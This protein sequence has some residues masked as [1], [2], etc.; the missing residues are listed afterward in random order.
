MTSNPDFK[1]T[2]KLLI[3]IVFSVL[4]FWLFSQS[5]LN[6]APTVQ[7]SLNLSSSVLNIGI[8]ITSLFSGL[9]IVL[10]GKLSDKLGRMKYVY[11]GL[12][13]NIIGSLILIS[14]NNSTLFIFGRILQG[15]SAAAIMPAT[16]SLIKVYYEGKDRQRALSYW[17]IGSW[18]GSG[19][20]SFFGG[21]LTSAFGWRSV[22][23][24]SIVI[25]IVSIFLL[26]GTPESFSIDEDD[27]KFDLIGLVLFI[28]SVLALNIF[29]T[30][31]SSLGWTSTI[32]IILVAV[33]VI[34]IIVFYKREKIAKNPFIDFELF[35]N[36]NYTAATLSNFL[37]NAVAGTMIVINSY[38]QQGR[39]LS[40]IQTGFLS[41]GYLAFVLITIRI[42]E[43]VLQK[44]GP[45]P[46][47]IYGSILA[48][49]GILLMDIT[50]LNGIAYLIAVFVGYSLFGIGLGLYATPSTDTAVSNVPNEKVGVAS[51]IYKMASS[52]G[53]AIGVAISA[54][55][56]NAIDINGQY[57]LGA[58]FGLGVNILFALLSLVSIV[59]LIKPN[60]KNL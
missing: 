52:L 48:V 32:S 6:I 36:G 15:L 41:L 4:T 11:I 53:G 43:K 20:C 10:A 19:F 30:K 16:I 24:F 29:I 38:V 25:S 44:V 3:G 26:K 60:N 13:L 59:L 12:F 14:F 39:G 27:S 42:G 21:A 55:L 22:F 47:M 37:L 40:T 34:G 33:F 45:K 7:K 35:K 9:F 1:G 8:S 58:N 57:T 46:P 28:V 54:S 2:N 23:I 51:G 49:I 31:G 17:S 5:F 56:Y 18:G 50:F